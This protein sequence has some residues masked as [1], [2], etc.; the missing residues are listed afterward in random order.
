MP[1]PG[2]SILVV[3]NF[4]AEA[5]FCALLRAFALF[6]GLAFAF[7]LRSLALFCARLRSSECGGLPCDRNRYLQSSENDIY[8]NRNVV[9]RKSIFLPEIFN[10]M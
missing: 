5:L 7:F 3:C 2:S 10:V 6:C 8:C 4:Y 1:N 9:Y